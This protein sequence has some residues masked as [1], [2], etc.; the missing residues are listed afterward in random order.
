[1]Q[2]QGIPSLLER[3]LGM[4]SQYACG[5]INQVIKKTLP[6]LGMSLQGIDV[7]HSTPGASSGTRGVGVLQSPG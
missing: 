2:T 1:M 6:D 5:L 3:E 4:F 7:G